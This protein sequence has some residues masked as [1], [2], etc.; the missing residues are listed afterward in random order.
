MK[1]DNEYV[2]EFGGNSD[3]FMNTIHNKPKRINTG[4]SDNVN[5]KNCIDCVNCVNCNYCKKCINCIGCS[6]CE[7]CVDCK[8][9]IHENNLIL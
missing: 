3:L 7:N 8:N 4:S 2:R 9:K 6:F 5:C 1:M